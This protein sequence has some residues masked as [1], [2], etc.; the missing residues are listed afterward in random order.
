M[1]QLSDLTH[2]PSP[3][4]LHTR[5]WEGHEYSF[6]FACWLNG[7]SFWCLWCRICAGDSEVTG[8]LCQPECG[9]VSQA[10]QGLPH[11]AHL[12][13]LFI[14]CILHWEDRAEGVMCVYAESVSSTLPLSHSDFLVDSTALHSSLCDLNTW[15]YTYPS[16]K[17]HACIYEECSV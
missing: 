14:S 4:F 6:C 3:L 8:K 16:W 2:H 11:L 13:E 15:S 12:G 1:L 9:A 17:L 7:S 5:N 10:V